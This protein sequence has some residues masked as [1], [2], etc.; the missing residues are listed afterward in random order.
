MPGILL[1][2]VILD[3]RPADIAIDGG[4]FSRIVAAGEFEQN[5][6][7]DGYEC[8]DCTGLTAI[9]GF[10]N[11]HTHAAMTL[12]RGVGEDLLFYD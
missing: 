6:P 7:A 1:K 10:I 8:L 5:F 3:N 12:M 2:N 9:P 4:K 11:S